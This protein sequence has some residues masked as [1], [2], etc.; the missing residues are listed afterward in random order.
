MSAVRFTQAR[1][2]KD[3]S[4]Q[5]VC[6]WRPVTKFISPVPRT[7]MRGLPSDRLSAS[8][9]LATIRI[10]ARP[11]HFPEGGRFFCVELSND[12]AVGSLQLD[13]RTVG[14]QR[15]NLTFGAGALAGLLAVLFQKQV[16][17]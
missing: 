11:F 14:G 6:D 3:I 5:L 2:S 4:D 12:V 1:V 10:G 8:K 13:K 15:T 17:T 16:G 7:I 9:L